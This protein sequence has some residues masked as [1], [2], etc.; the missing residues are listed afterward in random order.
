MRT[1]VRT[2]DS[3]KGSAARRQSHHRGGTMIR[4]ALIL[5][6]ALAVGGCGV[7]IMH[8]MGNGGGGGAGGGGGGVL[9]NVCAVVCGVGCVVDTCGATIVGCW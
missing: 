4:L 3:V 5:V 2:V 6:S 1:I 8:G 7:N 9:I